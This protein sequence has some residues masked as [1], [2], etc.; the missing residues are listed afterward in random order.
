VKFTKLLSDAA[1]RVKERHVKHK[2]RTNFDRYQHSPRLKLSRLYGY[3]L[4]EDGKAERIQEEAKVIQ[5]VFN[6]FVERKSAEE[7]KADLDRDDVRTRF[8]DRWTVAQ[9]MAM[10]RPIYSG[11]VVKK[12]GGLIRSD[13]YPAIVPQEIWQKAQKEV[14]RQVQ[15]AEIDP[16]TAVW[17]SRKD[18]KAYG[19]VN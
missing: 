16:V 4:K 10:I 17:G 19:K 7:I 6:M 14:K 2:T 5:R 15:A 11:L 3:K 18:T 8:N 12:S 13:V 1:A 9:L